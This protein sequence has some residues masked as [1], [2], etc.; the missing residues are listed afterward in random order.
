MLLGGPLLVRAVVLRWGLFFTGGSPQRNT[1][2][3]RHQRTQISLA[4]LAAM[5]AALGAAHRAV[6]PHLD[7]LMPLLF[8]KLHSLKES[9]RAAAEAALQ[10]GLCFDAFG[11]VGREGLRLRARL[12]V[13]PAV[14]GSRL[15]TDRHSP[16]HPYS[17]HSGRREFTLKRH[18]TL[19]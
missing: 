4:A 13:S 10:G 15:P 2:P 12:S 3:M 19:L 1:A 6:E 16:S 9:Q 8:L 7:K 5:R 11:V 17:H 18:N 14:D